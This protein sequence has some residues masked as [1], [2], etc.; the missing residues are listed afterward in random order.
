MSRWYNNKA[1]L[2]DMCVI[3]NEERPVTLREVKKL[4]AEGTILVPSVTSVIDQF[5]KFGLTTWKQKTSI[6]QAYQ[7][8]AEMV[9]KIQDGE[10]VTI[11]EE[12][13]EELCLAAPKKEGDDAASFGQRIHGIISLYVESGTKP[14][15]LSDDPIYPFVDPL[16]AEI[17]K[18][19]IQ[20]ICEKGLYQELTGRDGETLGYAGQPDNI[21]M[22]YIT[23]YKT[24]KTKKGKFTKYP[25]WLTQLAGYSLMHDTDDHTCLRNL[26]I[27]SNEPGVFRMF[28]YSRADLER[29]KRMFITALEYF[30]YD[31]GLVDINE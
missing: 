20:G 27:S 3:N 30:Y 16:L 15:F 7:I 12:E 2:V 10:R 22:E 8:L 25:N 24:Q 17:D 31:K 29:G 9:A 1:E 4:K 26:C 14:S 18:Y 5:E 21:H 19:K 28:N 11:T 6:K 13:H 23:D